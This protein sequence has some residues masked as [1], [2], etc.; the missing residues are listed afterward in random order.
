[1]ST[2]AVGSRRYHWLMAALPTPARMLCLSDI[3]AGYHRYRAELEAGGVIVVQS[4]DGEMI[5]GVLTRDPSM[6]GDAQLAQQIQAG[7]LPPLEQLLEEAPQ[8][9]AE[10]RKRNATSA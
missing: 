5:L 2:I 6:F 10:R 8:E 3:N 9:P 4:D 7:H 1:M